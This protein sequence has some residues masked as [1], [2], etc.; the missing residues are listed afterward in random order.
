MNIVDLEGY[1]KMKA[2]IQEMAKHPADM[3]MEEVLAFS[4]QQGEIVEALLNDIALLTGKHIDLQ[5]QFKIVSAQAYLAIQ[6]LQ[7]KEVIMEEELH[8]RWSKLMEQIMPEGMEEEEQAAEEERVAASAVFPGG[9]EPTDEDLGRILNGE[10]PEA[11]F[12][13][14]LETPE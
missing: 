14:K 11:V 8:G 13:G 10:D 5:N 9:Y 3:S 4:A 2:E 7:D 1:R 12:A 6:I